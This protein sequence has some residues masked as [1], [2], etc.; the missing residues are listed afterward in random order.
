MFSENDLRKIQRGHDR[1]QHIPFKALQRI[2]F[3]PTSMKAPG[4]F[5]GSI[6]TDLS[7]LLPETSEPVALHRS[8]GC[9]VP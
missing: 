6:S 4:K 2:S 7:V 3:P 1:D 5:V 9:G 8:S